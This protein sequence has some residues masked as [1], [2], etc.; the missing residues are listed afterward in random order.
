MSKSDAELIAEFLAKKG[1]TKLAQDENS[2]ITKKEF[3]KAA[4][5][6]LDLKARELDEEKLAERKL[7]VAREARHVGLS[8]S[9]ALDLAR[10]LSKKCKLREG[11][12]FHGSSFRR[13]N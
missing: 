5:G 1:A 10:S 9:E 3:Y 4:R 13:S 7:E 12:T 6:E 8:R 11:E 2:G